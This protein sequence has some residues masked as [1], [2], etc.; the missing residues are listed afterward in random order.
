M[1][2]TGSGSTPIWRT[3]FSLIP[4]SLEKIV[5]GAPVSGV[6]SCIFYLFARAGLGQTRS[7]AGRA[8]PGPG[9]VPG[10][11]GLGRGRPRAGRGAS[12]RRGQLF[13]A[14]GARVE[15]ELGWGRDEVGPLG[16]RGGGAGSGTRGGPGAGAGPGRP[17]IFFPLLF[18]LVRAA[19]PA[20]PP[21]PSQLWSRRY[22]DSAAWRRRLASEAFELSGWITSEWV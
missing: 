4:D 2:R 5:G 8:G 21:L 22:T 1:R 9:W 19:A 20:S 14:S 10:R 12:G 17:F 6:F 15:A 3:Y 11:A 7:R 13:R 18:F 16:R